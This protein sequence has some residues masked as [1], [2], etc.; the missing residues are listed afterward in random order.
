MEGTIVKPQEFVC[1]L[2]CHY[3]LI[4]QHGAVHHV[5]AEH[6]YHINVLKSLSDS[7]SGPVGNTLSYPEFIKEV[8]TTLNKLKY[9]LQIPGLISVDYESGIALPCP[10]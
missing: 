9:K 10:Y 7:I 6:Y 4:D 2:D 8:P 5:Q 3:N 1:P